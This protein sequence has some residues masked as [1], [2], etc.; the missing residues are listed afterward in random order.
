MFVFVCV[1]VEVGGHLLGVS[2][3]LPLCWSQGWNL[4]PQAWQQVSCL[5]SHLTSEG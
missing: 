4:G 1:C 2:P 5:L 3:L